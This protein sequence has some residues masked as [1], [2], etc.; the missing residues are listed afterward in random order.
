MPATRHQKTEKPARLSCR[1]NPHIKQRAEEAAA[2][3]GQSIT[4]FTEAALTEK[5]DAVF[6]RFESI[7]LT[8]RDFERFVS[9][10][11][12]PL[13]PTPEL[14]AAMREYERQR[15]EEPDGNW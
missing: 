12:N 14:I 8:E 9:S 10:I 5:A 13:P 11:T 7:K 4:D 3:L 6:E 2:L 1:V 15:A